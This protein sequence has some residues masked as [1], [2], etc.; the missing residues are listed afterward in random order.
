[1]AFKWTTIVP[2]AIA[3]ASGAV[4]AAAIG[5][6]SWGISVLAAS[7]GAGV[8]WYSSRAIGLAPVV[9][10]GPSATEIN[11]ETDLRTRTAILDNAP[12]PFLKFSAKGELRALNKS[13]RKL[14]A[15]DDVVIDPPASML[16]SISRA[17]PGLRD[18]LTLANGAGVR[19]F[20]LTVV[21]IAR[22]DEPFRL[23]SLVD[24]QP[25]IRVAEAAAM[26]DLIEILSHEIMNSLSAIT[27]MS[28]SV[29]DALSENSEVDRRLV[30]AT[31]IVA[32]RSEGLL[33]FVEGYRALARVP[34]P[35]LEDVSLREFMLRARSLFLGRWRG[36]HTELVLDLPSPDIIIRVDQQLLLQAVSTLLTNAVESAQL[37]EQS[38][39][40]RLAGGLSESHRPCISVTDNGLGVT[41]LDLEAIF[42]P[43]YTTKTGGT[44]V[45]LGIAK[46][47]I[48]SHGGEIT[49]EARKDEV[50][51]ARF[52]IHL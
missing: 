44:G 23:V 40:I 11:Q 4:L 7:V 22:P 24:I 30:G 42:K 35:L 38:P 41:G 34:D 20:S 25:Q 5:Y 16:E 37:A 49:V 6:Q 1:M 13:A 36:L 9:E 48:L 17:Q 29:H 3:L 18:T 15:T 26:K 45:G 27:S 2:T 33:R 31:D 43:F 32:K 8:L 10:R 52:T 50:P 47:I 51:G 14:F 46:Q 28:H 21:D 19:S 39:E 12:I